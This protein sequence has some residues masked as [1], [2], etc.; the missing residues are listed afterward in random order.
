[1][2]GKEK[3]RQDKLFSHHHCIINYVNQ[4]SGLRSLYFE[5]NKIS[6]GNRPSTEEGFRRASYDACAREVDGC[7]FAVALP[8]IVLISTTP[9]LWVVGIA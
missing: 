6:A 1:M 7:G 8:V 4:I 9:E 2:P 3:A 5:R